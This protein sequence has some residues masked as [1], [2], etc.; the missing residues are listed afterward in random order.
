MKRCTHCF[1]YSLGGPTFCNH[2]GR[3]FDV[4]ICSRGHR[5]S[6]GAQFCS[7]CG[8]QEMSTPAPP[9]DFL[10]RLSQLTLRIAL[11]LF[12]S[13]V[14]LAAVL[15]ILYS[16]DWNAIAPRLTLLVLVLGF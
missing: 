12:I 7:E 1:R 16:L 9:A 13:V 4:K 3:T 8:S 10:F 11:V 6:R 14:L 15:G 5:N 2:C